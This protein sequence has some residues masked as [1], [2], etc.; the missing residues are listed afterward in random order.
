MLRALAAID[1]G[2]PSRAVDLLQT[3]A[4][5]DLAAP[6]SWAGF[7]GNLYSIYVRGAAHLAAHRGAQAASEFRTIL[8]HPGIAVSDPVAVVARLQLARA[9]A[10]AGDRANARIAYEDFLAFWHAADPDIPIFVR[11]KTEYARL[12]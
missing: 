11:A 7:F 6:G 1:D 12:Q 4:P 5:F 9:L 3:A 10:M 2:E 8:S